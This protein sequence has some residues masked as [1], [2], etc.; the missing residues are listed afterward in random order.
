M[1]PEDCL[2]NMTAR[3]FPQ[4]VILQ[5]EVYSNTSEVWQERERT[6]QHMMR[7]ESGEKD[8]RSLLNVE[9]ARSYCETS[10]IVNLTGTKYFCHLMIT[11]LLK[12][13]GSDQDAVDEDE[14]VLTGIPVHN[15]STEKEH[16]GVSELVESVR[17]KFFNVI[18]KYVKSMK[19]R[20]SMMAFY[21]KN[22][23]LL[24]I[25]GKYGRYIYNNGNTLL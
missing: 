9:W 2:L 25:F 24:D 7:N 17:E 5:V 4:D 12:V 8:L 22:Y 14:N 6:L 11:E 16:K 19:R 20:K 3:P 21:S 23:T 18:K 13:T 15:T 10:F 1:N